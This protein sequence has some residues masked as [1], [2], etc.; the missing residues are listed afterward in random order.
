MSES[1][2][3]LWRLAALQ[4]RTD[5][6]RHT[7]GHMG[8]PALGDPC[9]AG[10]STEM[11]LFAQDDLARFRRCHGYITMG[12]I[13]TGDI[14]EV[15]I[16]SGDE[17]APVGLGRFPSP[18]LGKSAELGLFSRTNGLQHRL[19]GEVEELI[20]L[21]VG[22]GVRSAHEAVSDH[23]DVEFLQAQGASHPP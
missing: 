21:S 19:M 23:A 12:V 20:D 11:G 16:G 4:L 18:I 3:A 15:D 8:P 5:S 2:A 22:V 1:D 7:H 13:R 10:R 14:D 17:R 6:S 9:E